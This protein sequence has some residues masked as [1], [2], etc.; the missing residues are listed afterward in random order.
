MISP[1]ARMSISTVM[2]MKASAALRAPGVA[3]SF[4]GESFKASLCCG[5]VPRESAQSIA[6]SRGGQV[7]RGLRLAGFVLAEVVRQAVVDRARGDRGVADRD[8]DLVERADHVADRVQAVDAGLLFFI[9]VQLAMVVDGRAEHRRQLRLRVVAEYRV[10]GVEAMHAA[11]FAL[12]D[13]ALAIVLQR[14]RR[15]QHA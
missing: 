12:E 13:A 11:A 3:M 1:K 15:R 6:A 9:D 2:K 4:T 5:A 10:D 14:G 7:D 8:A